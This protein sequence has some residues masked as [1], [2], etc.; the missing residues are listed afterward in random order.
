MKTLHTDPKHLVNILSYQG[1]DYL[2]NTVY[3]YIKEKQNFSINHILDINLKLKADLKGGKVSREDVIVIGTTLKRVYEFSKEEGKLNLGYIQLYTK[4]EQALEIYN[5]TFKGVSFAL[6]TLMEESIMAKK[7]WN[8]NKLEIVMQAISSK[9]GKILSELEKEF[10]KMF[11]RDMRSALVEH[12][13][14][15]FDTPIVL[16]IYNRTLSR[17]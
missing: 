8:L 2:N 1:I 13:F 4:V 9:Y 11:L 17:V 5:S 16:E 6:K 12:K 10:I 7:T 3:G 14:Y 15:F